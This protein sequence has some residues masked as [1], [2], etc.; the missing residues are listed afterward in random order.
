MLGL[1]AHLRHAK[2]FGQPNANLFVHA[3]PGLDAGPFVQA[4]PRNIVGC[5]R[6]ME[7]GHAW[8]HAKQG[9]V[10]FGRA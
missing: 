4:K 3:N 6:H 7:E 2:L 8:G 10:R 1:V 9:W 5:A